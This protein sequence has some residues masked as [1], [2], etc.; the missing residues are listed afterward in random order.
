MSSDS[1]LGV[2]LVTGASTDLGH[3]IALRL[4]K[5][6]DIAVN[7]F[8]EALKPLEGLKAQIENQGRKSVII[9]GNPSIESLVSTIDIRSGRT[10]LIKRGFVSP[11]DLD[12]VTAERL[13]SVCKQAEEQ[14]SKRAPGAKMNGVFCKVANGGHY[15]LVVSNDKN[16]GQSIPGAMGP[17][18][19][20][21]RGLTE[22][23]GLGVDKTNVVDELVKD[24]K[25]PL[26]NFL[27]KTVDETA[28]RPVETVEDVANVVAFL[29]SKSARSIN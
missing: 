12:K 15:A 24:T 26:A 11:D 10:P 19:F 29:M 8:P 25:V 4:A 9:V 5:D 7:D 21:I 3:A 13:D 20:A 2:A 16:A 28:D 23:A 6:F 1:S 17:L 14:L 27:G 22:A 18:K